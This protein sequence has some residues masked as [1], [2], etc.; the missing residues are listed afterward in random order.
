MSIL[1]R[2]AGTREG[3]VDAFWA[4]SLPDVDHC[5]IATVPEKVWT[6][7]GAEPVCHVRGI[8]EFNRNML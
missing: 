7:R 8:T 6:D 5:L 4:L 1:L 2:L 3:S